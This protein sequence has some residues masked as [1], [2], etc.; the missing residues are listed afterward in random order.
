[1]LLFDRLILPPIGI[2]IERRKAAPETSC[3]HSEKCSDISREQ[4]LRLF[5]DIRDVLMYETL[6]NLS[7]V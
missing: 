1:M 4:I 2:K 6:N 5:S 3:E 7:W